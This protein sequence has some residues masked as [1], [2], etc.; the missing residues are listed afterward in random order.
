MFTECTPTKCSHTEAPNKKQE[1]AQKAGTLSVEQI[2][3]K[4]TPKM[5]KPK[6]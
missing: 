1:S 2:N 3:D 4:E 6:S 5:S